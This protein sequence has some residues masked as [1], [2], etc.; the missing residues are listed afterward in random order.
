MSVSAHNY[1]VGE[2]NPSIHFFPPV[3]SGP[4]DSSGPQGRIAIP[5]RANP[6]ASESAEAKPRP[7]LA[8]DS[9]NF[10][11]LLLERSPATS[12]STIGMTTTA[13][14]RGFADA[15]EC[16]PYCDGCQPAHHFIV[17]CPG[18]VFS[19]PGQRDYRQGWLAGLARP[20]FFNRP[21]RPFGGRIA[22][23]RL[24]QPGWLSLQS[25]VL[26]AAVLKRTAAHAGR[27]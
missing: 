19:S 15:A 23:F 24:S 4:D 12:G 11:V 16:R 17:L 8:K 7:A 5:F 6:S 1:K 10:R 22:S 21:N 14:S 20:R 2:K 13:Y 18:Y 9:P 25:A 27:G 3:I 26:P